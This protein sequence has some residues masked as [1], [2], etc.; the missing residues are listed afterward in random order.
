MISIFIPTKNRSD[1]LARALYYYYKAGFQGKIYIGDSS[2]DEHAEKNEHLIDSLKD[3]LKIIYRYF[4]NPP[5]LNEGMC[6]KTLTEIA[7][8][9]YAVCSGDDDFLIPAGLERCVEFLEN[10]PDY[11]AAHGFRANISLGNDGV[12][13]KIIS[14]CIFPGHIMESEIASERWIAY[15]REPLSTQYYVHRMEAWRR[16]YRDVDSV[17]IRYFGPE[18]L[19]CSLSV[20]M[21]KIK[22]LDCLTTVFQKGTHNTS[23][24]QQIPT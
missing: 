3:K 5:Y 22:R 9:P 4:P 7:D 13:G 12:F 24:W 6:V 1:Y 11:T 23:N 14:G 19:P 15:I 21:G 18:L 8:T 20:I 10:H 17:P 2:N 16:M